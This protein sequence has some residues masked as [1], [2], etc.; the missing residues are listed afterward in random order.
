MVGVKPKDTTK[1][2]SGKRKD[3]FLAASKENIRDLSQSSVL[4]QQY[5]GIFKLG[6]YAYSYK[7]LASACIFMKGLG[8]RKIHYRIGARINRAQNL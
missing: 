6:I 2:K 3:L 7:D 1:P 8:H 4:E 5:C